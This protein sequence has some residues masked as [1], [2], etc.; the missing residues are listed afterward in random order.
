M[1]IVP[2]ERA[3]VKLTEPADLV[4]LEALRAGRARSARM[5]L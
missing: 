1:Q 2:G 3:N 4:V 5:E